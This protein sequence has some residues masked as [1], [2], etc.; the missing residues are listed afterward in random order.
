[1]AGVAEGRPMMKLFEGQVALITGA[2]GGIG[3]A[4]ARAF[5]AAGAAVIVADRETA[6]IEAAAD[7]LRAARYQAL[8][9]TCDVTEREQVKAMVEQAVK[10]FGRLDAA[11]NNAGINCAA[12]PMGET[13]DDEFDK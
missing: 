1:M 7:Q 4:A 3:F 13:A 9:V 8:P 12:A 11:F 6:L 2:G 10:T 5:A